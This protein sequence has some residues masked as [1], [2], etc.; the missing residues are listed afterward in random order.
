MYLLA[1]TDYRQHLIPLASRNS[2]GKF[3]IHL[4]Y[5]TLI[6]VNVVKVSKK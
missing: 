6:A 1:F 4:M 5:K 3:Y 2:D